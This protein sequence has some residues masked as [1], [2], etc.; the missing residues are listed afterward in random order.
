MPYTGGPLTVEGE[1]NK[2][3]V[4]VANGRNIAGVH[5]RTDGRESMLLGE[6]VAISMLQDTQR[7]FNENRD[8]FFNGFKFKGFLENKINL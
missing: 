2:I 5:W 1:L 7:T 8:N 3:G 6:Q 4:N